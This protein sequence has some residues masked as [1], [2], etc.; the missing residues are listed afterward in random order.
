MPLIITSDVHSGG[1]EKIQQHHDTG[2][3]T[4]ISMRVDLPPSY[5]EVDPKFGEDV[6]EKRA[7]PSRQTEGVV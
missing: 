6:K 5:L 4:Y 2:P 3:S 7:R 1:G